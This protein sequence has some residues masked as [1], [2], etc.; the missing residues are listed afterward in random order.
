M[1]SPD[2]L[3]A[4]AFSLRA[5]A[6]IEVPDHYGVVVAV[7]PRGTSCEVTVDF[8][9]EERGGLYTTD[10]QGIQVGQWLRYTPHAD[11][12]IEGRWRVAEPG[13]AP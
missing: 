4:L 13:E 11:R 3:D 6:R 9:Y 12:V 10:A 8:G 5:A 1:Y 7:T 2:S